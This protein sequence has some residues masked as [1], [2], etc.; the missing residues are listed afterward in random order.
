MAILIIA[1][2]RPQRLSKRLSTDTNKDIVNAVR[3][4]GRNVSQSAFQL[5]RPAGVRAADGWRPQRLSKRL[6]TD[7]CALARFSEV[8][9]GRNVSQSAFQ[10][11]HVGARVV[12]GELIRRN[13]SQSAFQLTHDRPHDEPARARPQRLSKRL[14][15][16]TPRQVLPRFR[17][18]KPQRLSKRLSTDTTSPRPA[19][20]PAPRAATSLKAPFN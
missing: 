10:L 16:D 9:R 13:V 17:P 7:T 12:S 14:S 2:I 20:R 1:A 19:A 18:R 5:T 11:T 8:A 3:E 15:T 6:S 4:V